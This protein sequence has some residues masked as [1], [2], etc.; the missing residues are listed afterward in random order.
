MNFPKLIRSTRRIILEETQEQ[1][2]K[3][4]GVEK[5]TVSRW[6]K[7]E[8]QAPYDVLYFVLER[9]KGDMNSGEN[10]THSTAIA[11]TD[12]S[13]AMMR[14]QQNSIAKVDMREL[15]ELAEIFVASGAFSDIK[16][17]AQAQIK[18]LAGNELGFSPLVSMTG[19]HFFQGKVTI[20][21]NLIASLIKESTKYDYEIVEHS[22]TACAVQFY[23][24]GQK[25]GV[26]VRYTIEDAKE[27]QLLTKDPWKKYPADLLFAAV[28]RQGARRY[29]A[30]VLRGTTASTDTAGDHE[31]DETPFVEGPVESIEKV[32]RDGEI[33]VDGE[34]VDAVT[35]EVLEEREDVAGD[36]PVD[37][38]EAPLVDLREAVLA[39][40]NECRGVDRERANRFLGSKTI[41]QLDAE[42]LTAFLAEFPA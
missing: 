35:G 21:S 42:G 5:S 13:T 16:Q 19:I 27:A 15:K 2:G 12:P 11:K 18:I 38:A 28:I 33:V 7:G 30:D 4:F 36:P 10:M 24:N 41:R 39:R 6:E 8:Y 26:P 29:C 9:S 20:G 40:Y 34:T 14:R 17:V 1:F 23:E 37:A 31:Y 3:W 32:L 22:N 25:I